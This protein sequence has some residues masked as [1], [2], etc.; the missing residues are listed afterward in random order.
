MR[1]EFAGKCD[2]GKKR[3]MNQDAMGMYQAKEAGLFVVAD[4]MGGHTNGDK[5]SRMVVTELQNWWNSFSPALFGC[6]FRKMLMAIEQVIE[7]ANGKIFREF[8]QRGICG[9]TV[10][11]LFIYKNYYGVI[12]AGDSRC[13]LGQGRKWKQLTLDEVWENQPFLTQ[14]ER[15]MKDH[16]HRGK[17]INAIGIK[18]EGKC[19]VLTDQ[20]PPDAIFLLC[21]DGLYKFCADKSMKN[22][23]KRSKTRKD[24]EQ[25]VE[26]LIDIVY[27]NGADDN[28]SV[29]LVRCLEDTHNG[30]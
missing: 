30:K 26:R 19:R 18:E 7:Y 1:L 20:I 28:V 10:T 14:R 27:Q 13:Y 3:E 6:E 4:G 8:N 17:L 16:P 25:S 29:I 12:Y 5:A 22:I 15:S 2:I 24:L 21:S 23:V 9:T 11:V